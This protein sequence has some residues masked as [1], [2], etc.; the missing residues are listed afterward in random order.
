MGIVL[1][2]LSAGGLAT[3]FLWGL[4]AD[5]FGE[6]LTLAAGL[7]GAG[8]CIAG[9]AFAPGFGAL[10]ALVALAGAAGFGV[11]SSSARAVMQWFPPD[12]RGYA[13]G[14]RQAA[15]PMG[16]LAT[17][18]GLPAIEAA[19]GIDAALF[20]LAGV[21]LAGA[22]VGGILVRE[23]RIEEPARRNASPWSLRDPRLW[24]LGCASGLYVIAQIAIMGFVVLFLHD[25]RGFSTRSG[26][27]VL[28][29]VYV[30]GGFLRIAGG[31]WSDRQGLRVVPLRHIGLVTFGTMAIVAALVDA[32]A[33]MLV[34]AL[35]VAG[36]VSMAWNGLS[37]TAAAELGG[38][39]RSGA[40]IGV[41]Q[42]FLAVG[43]I[44]GPIAFAATVDVSSWR[45]AFVTVG[46]VALAGRWLL[47]PLSERRH[48]TVAAELAETGED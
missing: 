13:L 12:E 20:T 4:A 30:L 43:T 11:N 28:G 14:L 3:V 40:A 16:G 36:G 26:A 42:T 47:A 44:V 10:V 38:R 35:V 17:A 46:L 2:A 24:R 18:L 34:P 5:R 33:F 21:C 41:Q 8:A 31:R 25:A 39:E 15:V 32:P 19:A 7:G 29:A 37:V 45:A 9:L 27:V 22:L 6:R 23:H 1:A 48:A